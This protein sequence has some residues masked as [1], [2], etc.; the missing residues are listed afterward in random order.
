METT[1]KIYVC[2]IIY[3]VALL[4]AILFIPLPTSVVAI[5]VYAEQTRWARLQI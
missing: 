3:P 4:H 1:M 5:G 2:L